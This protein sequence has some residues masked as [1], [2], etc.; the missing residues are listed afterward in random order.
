M[1]LKNSKEYTNKNNYQA[2]TGYK[3]ANT[4]PVSIIPETP[5]TVAP[6]KEIKAKAATKEKAVK[7]AWERP[8]LDKLYN[9]FQPK[10]N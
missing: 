8:D 10:N 5:K 7:F 3:T 1:M 4:L 6:E 9:K 2:N